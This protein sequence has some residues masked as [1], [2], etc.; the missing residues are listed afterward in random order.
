MSEKISTELIKELEYLEEKDASKAIG[1]LPRRLIRKDKLNIPKEENY[2]GTQSSTKATRG[3]AKGRS[4]RRPSL[5][6]SSSSE[7]ETD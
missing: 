2:Y 1:F 3:N 6:R 5:L 7:V 4:N